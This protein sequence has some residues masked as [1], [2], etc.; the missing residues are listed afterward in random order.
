MRQLPQTAYISLKLPNSLLPLSALCSV[1][2]TNG[3]RRLDEHHE[4]LFLGTT[5]YTWI[6]LHNFVLVG[7]ALGSREAATCSL[8][9]TKASYSGHKRQSA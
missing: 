6:P 1:M 9:H 8:K 4:L 2:T 7:A 5:G 3:G